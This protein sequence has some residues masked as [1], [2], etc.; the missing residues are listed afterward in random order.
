M[1]T[2]LEPASEEAF[3]RAT[4]SP[5]YSDTNLHQLVLLGQE[6]FKTPSGEADEQGLLNTI[7]EFFRQAVEYSEDILDE[8]PV[9]ETPSEAVLVSTY[10]AVVV[11]QHPKFED[12]NP[13]NLQL[14]Y[15]IQYYYRDI[16]FNLLS[17][18]SFQIRADIYKE[19]ANTLYKKHDSSDSEYP[20]VRN[21]VE[22]IV[23]VNGRKYLRVHF[24]DSSMEILRYDGGDPDP[25]NLDVIFEDEYLYI[26][27]SKL[28]EDLDDFFGNSFKKL[29]KVQEA[30]LTSENVRWLVNGADD[31]H[32]RISNLYEDGYMDRLYTYRG[33]VID[34]LNLVREALEES[35]IDLTERNWLEPAEIAEAARNYNPKYHKKQEVLKDWETSM[36]VG[37]RLSN[38]SEHKLVASKERRD[39]ESNL[40]YI[41]NQ[42]S[43]KK[44]TV[45]KPEDLLELPCWQNID[46][47]LQEEV[48]REE[49]LNLVPTVLF[50]NQHYNE[51]SNT[52]RWSKAREFIK[53]FIQRYPWYD[54]ATSDENID[55]LFE[56]GT[57][58]TGNRYLPRNCD[59]ASM[60]RWCIGKDKCPYSIYGSLNFS[61]EALEH[62]LKDSENGF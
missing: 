52:F 12:E 49:M 37:K 57:D 20:T 61:E 13:N 36:K 24:S 45:T 62:H 55:A 19:I 30:N 25:E 31:I 7:E 29:L 17:E 9:V 39:G 56:Y 2:Q 15:D 48:D 38:R 47:R 59:N 26:H 43:S 16:I 34:E 6:Q 51:E 22:D 35:N 10:A 5:E 4:I 11:K 53:E 33:P 23:D 60:Q 46:E 42:F 32:R 50:L 14:L 58:E 8:P 40:Y 54:E 3:F 1:R 44:L 41:K 28:K 27:L 18:E 21:I